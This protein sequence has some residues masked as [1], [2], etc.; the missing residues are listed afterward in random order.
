MWALLTSLISTVIGGGITGLAGVAIQRFFD[1]KNQSAKLASDAQANAHELAMKDMDIKAMSAE[2]L[3]GFKTS[4]LTATSAEAVSDNDVFKQALALE[5]QR[6]ASTS[7]VTNGQNWILVI[8]DV[9]RGL[10]RPGL[11]AYLAVLTSLIYW[12]STKVLSHE[13]MTLDPEKAY[14]LI[15]QCMTTVLYL[16]TTCTLFYFGTR[17]KASEA[18]SRAGK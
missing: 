18:K 3:A 9:I 11:T 14:D 4:V 10:V 16:F 6:Y 5:P 12:Q 2:S 13:G 7:S 1:L 15:N 8:L 17:N